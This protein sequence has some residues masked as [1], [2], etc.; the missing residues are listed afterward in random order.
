MRIRP[1]LALSVAAVLAVLLAGCTAPATPGEPEVAPPVDLCAVAAPSG[2]VSDAIVVSGEFGSPASVTLAAP[3]TVGGIERRVV[4]EGEGDPLGS[5]D[6]VDYAMTVFDASTGTQVLTEGYDSAASLS[7]PAA[8]LAQYLGCAPVGSRVVLAVP[9]TDQAAASVWVVDVL[10]TTPGR[11]TGEDQEPVDGMP[12]V[13]LGETG[14][15]TIT[16]PGGEPPSKTRVAE[17]KKGDGA[18]IAPGD[19][20]M[21]QYTGVRWSTGEV[22]DSSWRNGTPTAVVTTDLIPGYREALEGHTVGSQV[23]VVIPP[24]DAYGEGEI[25]KEDL[26]GETL[27]FVIDILEAQPTA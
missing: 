5:G 4:V 18:V 2:P 10:G 20:V 6:L 12:T 15:P 13:Q 7:V 27:V 11:A 23:L 3:L 24:A 14:A 1:V 19:S 17:L 16:V 8:S 21:V 25:N 22:F 26:T 9:E